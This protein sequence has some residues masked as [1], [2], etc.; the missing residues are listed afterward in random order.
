M[1]PRCK[2][3]SHPQRA[4]IDAAI[5]A[6]ESLRNIAQRF[7]GPSAWSIYRHTKHAQATLLAAIGARDAALME[8]LRAKLDEL[9]MRELT[10]SQT[11]LDTLRSERTGGRRITAAEWEAAIDGIF[12]GY[13][14]I[15]SY[16]RRL[17]RDGVG[18]GSPNS[19]SGLLTGVT[20]IG[21]TLRRVR[22]EKAAPNPK[23]AV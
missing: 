2:T 11:H 6:G 5:I 13:V 20:G 4:K 22:S 19:R 7:E 16:I 23:S 18:T 8:N 15:I 17:L 9:L 1:P 12:G 14:R 3:C 10:N 21:P